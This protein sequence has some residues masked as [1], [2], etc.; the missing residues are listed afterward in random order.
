M[1]LQ[2]VMHHLNWM[3]AA[4]AKQAMSHPIEKDIADSCKQDCCNQ[5]GI[6]S[7]ISQVV[8]SMFAFCP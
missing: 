2:L 4:A 8:Q 7:D 3:N 6:T 1:L 5:T